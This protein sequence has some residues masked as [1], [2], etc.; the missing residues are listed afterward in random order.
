MSSANRPIL[1]VVSGLREAIASN[2]S[3]RDHRVFHVVLRA[4][5]RPSRFVL[6]ILE[7]TLDQRTYSGDLVFSRAWR[8][9]CFQ[10][11]RESHI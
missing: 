10:S 8:I 1:Q 3:R 5:G 4:S 11:C 2:T 6:K 9:F 7:I